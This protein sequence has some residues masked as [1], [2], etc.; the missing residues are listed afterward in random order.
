MARG[1]AGTNTQISG[2]TS[3]CRNQTYL[4]MAGW[5]RRESSGT[6]QGWGPQ[7]SGQHRIGFLWFSDNTMYITNGDGDSTYYS[8]VEKNSTGWHH[9][10]LVF[11]GTQAT[12]LL[13]MVVFY[14]GSKQTLNIINVPTKTSN[15]STMEDFRIGRIA[16]NSA[17]STGDFAELAIWQGT[18]NFSQAES[19]ADGFSPRKIA[20][21]SLV[22]YSP[23]VRNIS[24]V[25]G[26]IT[27]TDASSTAQP[28]PRIYA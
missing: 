9:W 12:N 21:D 8:Y 2:T 27:L 10:M 1:F 11:D 23:L 22:Y 3:S 24:D 14:D 19:L 16:G 4:T 25:V 13:R 5:I 15:D 26:G 17:W 6:I 28:H 20:P 7:P 18:L